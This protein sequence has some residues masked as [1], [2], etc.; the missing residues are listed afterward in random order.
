MYRLRKATLI[1][2]LLIGVCESKYL[3][4]LSQ[5]TS[6]KYVIGY[7]NAGAGMFSAIAGVLNNIA[8]CERN[9]KIPVV[10]WGPEAYGQLRYPTQTCNTPY[11]QEGGFNG[12]TNVWE[13]YFEPVSE[14][15]YLLG[16]QITCNYYVYH[17]PR[18]LLIPVHYGNPRSCLQI[19]CR[20]RR[21]EIKYLVDKYI[22]VKPEVM[23]KVDAFYEAHFKG[24]KTIAIH[25]RGTDKK[26]EVAQVTTEDICSVA[27]EYAAKNPGCQFF[28]CTD[29]LS[30]LSRAQEL[31]LG[32]IITYDAHR[33]EDGKPLHLY[34]QQ[35]SPAKLG[36]DVII[37]ALLMS[38]CDLFV[39]TCNNVAIGVMYLNPSLDTVL[40]VPPHEVIP[41]CI[42]WP[43]SQTNGNHV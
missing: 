22:K 16:D 9:G 32:N 6:K 30:L 27:N 41:N 18:E 39:H 23:N 21:K 36:E 26:T 20:E 14:E 33:S 28:V 31:L 10:Y 5:D 15:R 37:E 34:I 1:T 35:Q 24:K 2:C 29:E 43:A 38:R 17:T 42:T 19:E 13:Y 7:H 8:W 11:Y 12:S 3:D 40:I 4:K 25:M